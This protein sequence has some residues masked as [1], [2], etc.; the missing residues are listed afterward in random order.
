MAID[1]EF[2]G[3]EFRMVEN[4]MLYHTNEIDAVRLIRTSHC[5]RWDT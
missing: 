5:L 2:R 3:A 4:S 1:N